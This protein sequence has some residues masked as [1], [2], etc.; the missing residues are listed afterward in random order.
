VKFLERFNA[1]HF[2]TDKA[3]TIEDLDAAKDES[4]VM[5]MLI[6]LFE[7]EDK[8]LAWHLS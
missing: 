1:K 2:L 8:D 3:A 4:L 6:G 5:Q 7:K